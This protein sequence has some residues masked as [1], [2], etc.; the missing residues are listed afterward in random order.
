[1]KLSFKCI[2]LIFTLFPFMNSIGQ[3]NSVLFHYYVEDRGHAI[4]YLFFEA[5][6]VYYLSFKKPC[7]LEFCILSDYQI[8]ND[9]LKT[10]DFGSYIIR[11]NKLIY[12]LGNNLIK[13]EYYT[14]FKT[15]NK[16]TVNCLKF[17]GI[18]VDSG[19]IIIPEHLYRGEVDRFIILP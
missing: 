18:Q 19:R 8:K 7:T 3:T 12:I 16:E 13:N 17:Y 11:R 14:A 15:I 9:T 10:K 1:M 5:G 2:A 4:N 6:E